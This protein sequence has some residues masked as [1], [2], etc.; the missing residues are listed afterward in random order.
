MNNRQRLRPDESGFTLLEL[1]VV[2]GIIA[3]LATLVAPQ[4]L[5]YLSDARVNTASA[6]IRNL[7]AA[8]ELYYLDTGSYPAGDAG[9]VALVDA[10]QGVPAWKGPYLKTKSGLKDPWG[11]DYLYKFPGER[12]AFEIFSMGRDGKVGG[13]GEDTDLG[14][15]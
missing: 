2:L 8:V 10:P 5:R 6:Q 4:V 7:A 1:L 12:A 13:A 15:W 3:L 11:K 14:N 9:L